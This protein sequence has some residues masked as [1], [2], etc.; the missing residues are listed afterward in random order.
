MFLPYRQIHNSQANA[1]PA[2]MRAFALIALLWVC[3]CANEPCGDD[4]NCP[5]KAPNLL[6][7]T[8][9]S[10]TDSH[11][12]AETT[13]SDD[14]AEASDALN[15]TAESFSVGKTVSFGCCQWAHTRDRCSRDR[16]EVD[17]LHGT[18]HLP[19]DQHTRTFNMGH[20]DDKL[21]WRC[22]RRRAPEWSRFEL[23]S[24]QVAVKRCRSCRRRD[25]RAIDIWP[26]YCPPSRTIPSDT[27][28]ERGCCSVSD[29]TIDRCRSAI[30]IDV[31]IPGQGRQR[32]WKG[33]HAEFSWK[34]PW[35]GYKHFVWY[36]GGTQERSRWSLYFNTLQVRLGCDGVISWNPYY[37]AAE[38]TSDV[39]AAMSSQM[40][41]YMADARGAAATV[42]NRKED[43]C[44]AAALSYMWE[45]QMT[46]SGICARNGHSG[47]P[48][49]FASSS[50]LQTSEEDVSSNA[51]TNSERVAA[52]E[53]LKERRLN[54]S[55][56][57]AEI[58]S[59]MRVLGWHGDDGDF[60]ALEVVNE[61]ERGGEG[62]SRSDLVRHNAT[63]LPLILGHVA[64]CDLKGGT[65]C[66]AIGMQ[67]CT[68]YCVPKEASCAA[69]MAEKY[70]L[71]A[72]DI[73]LMAIDLVVSV[74]TLGAGTVA[75]Q[76]LKTGAKAATVT[77]AKAAAK[78][79]LTEMTKHGAK[80]ITKG[81]LKA[82]LKQTVKLVAGF[83][84]AA[85]RHVL[86]NLKKLTRD[87]LIKKGIRFVNDQVASVTR[88][89][90][91]E[92]LAQDGKLTP[93]FDAECTK[94]IE[95]IA[96][97]GADATPAWIVEKDNDWGLAE[98]FDVTGAVSLIKIFQESDCPAPI[99]SSYGSACPR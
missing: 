98:T 35:T 48:S 91:S 44:A 55:S 20:T 72:I 79:A 10:M 37:C 22:N 4:E 38:A 52:S 83:G 57:N 5:M 47:R 26:R 77:A 2:N 31:E 39:L 78:K 43:V 94:A 92:A 24:N 97:T 58:I 21:R 76:A 41:N 14:V 90:V 23:P 34:E 1:S 95:S 62:M 27:P 67:H 49:M 60:S 96:K 84:K 32:V 75:W 99:P 88:S 11:T 25:D 54:A 70:I 68:C 40:G 36:C 71:A 7:V 59:A 33:Q 3:S 12:V 29:G 50:L 65:D 61:L 8:K 93:E 89:I 64:F 51:V 30:Y 74:Y 66:N 13:S 6:A 56:F 18:G 53:L 46:P 80:K 28:E 82:A 9:S 19:D 17:N 86:A 85:G 73:T 45:Q 87:T 15:D 69:I 81:M 42:K 63:V 16:V